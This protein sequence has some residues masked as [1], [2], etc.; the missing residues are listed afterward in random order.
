MTLAL[1]WLGVALA[2]LGHGFLWTGLVNR[3][4]G[5]G[6]PRRLI[7]AVTAALVGAFVGLPLAIAWRQPAIFAANFNPF[8]AHAAG[9]PYLWLS[10]A[11][12]G[13]ALIAKPWIERRRYDPAVLRKWT[14]EPRD[15]VRALGGRPLVGP[16]ANLLGRLPWNEALRPT[17]DRKRLAL[18]TLPTGL[19]GLTIAH[20]SD[21]HMTGR[22]GHEFYDYLVRQVNDLR[23]D[24]IAITGDIVEHEACWP[25]LEPTLGRLCAPL[26]VYFILGNHDALIDARQT[27]QVLVDAGLTCLSGRSLR[28]EWNGVAVTLIGNELPWMPPSQRLELPPKGAAGEEFRLVLCH[29]P[30]QFRYCVQAGAD[31]ALAGHTHGGQIQ[32]PLL[33][34]V[35][36]P[37]LHGTRYACGV[38]RRGGAVL[39]VSRGLAG[40]TPLRWRCPPEI[41]LLELISADGASAAGN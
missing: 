13:A 41:A 28:V 9:A 15:A 6:G 17:V 12:G 10:A 5:W 40:E 4:H 35:M 32:L 36:S 27:R 19:Q 33:G 2:A 30:D 3:L 18:P 24:V 16:T 31:L 38:F 14:I 29:S 1:V 37:S 26:G 8:A 25:W 21:L 39:H 11:V 7:K 22:L 20:L 34:A 23:P